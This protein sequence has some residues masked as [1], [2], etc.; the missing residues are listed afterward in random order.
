MLPTLF[1]ISIY[2]Y[3]ADGCWWCPALSL[4][5]TLFARNGEQPCSTNEMLSDVCNNVQVGVVSAKWERPL[6][7][8]NGAESD[9]T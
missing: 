2:Y 1:N 3:F 6:R 7:T 4:S 5:T 9:E 8:S